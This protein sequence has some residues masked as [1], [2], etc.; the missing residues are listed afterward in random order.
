[1]SSRRHSITRASP[2]GL[3]RVLSVGKTSVLENTLGRHVPNAQYNE[4]LKERIHSDIGNIEFPSTVDWDQESIVSWESLLYFVA[5]SLSAILRDGKTA[6]TDSEIVRSNVNLIETFMTAMITAHYRPDRIARS[7]DQI[8][9]RYRVAMN[10]LARAMT[11]FNNVVQ[12]HCDQEEA[13]HQ[14]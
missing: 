5:S 6:V 9:P 2:G 10:T 12:R 3:A 11:E 4:E 1:M 13:R 14:K 8:D 7:P